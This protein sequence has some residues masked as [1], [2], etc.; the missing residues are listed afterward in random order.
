M[1]SRKGP[2]GAHE[3]GRG[4]VTAPA[5][6]SRWAAL[7]HDAAKPLTRR[8]MRTGEV[9]FFGHERVGATLANRLLKRLKADKATPTPRSCSWSTCTC[10]APRTMPRPGPTAPCG[11]WRSKPA[12]RCDD[13]L[14]LAAADV[15][16]ARAHKQR[17]AAARV[18]GLR[19]HLARL[20]AEHA[21]AEA[22][23]PA[24][25][26]RPDDRCSTVRRAAGSPASR[27]I[28]GTW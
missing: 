21:L 25:R 23:E 15:T 2:L 17:A 6:V 19:D 24:R 8:S 3:T 20:E 5:D 18:Q 22:A 28:C 16:S 27:I 14:D 7:L 1:P 9:H 13:L 4:A 11:A 26:Q 12:M 10:A